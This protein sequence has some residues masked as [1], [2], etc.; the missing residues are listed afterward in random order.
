MAV[1]KIHFNFI[2]SKNRRE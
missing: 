1:S 2:F